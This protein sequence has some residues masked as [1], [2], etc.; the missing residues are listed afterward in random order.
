LGG[1]KKGCYH[2]DRIR[3]DPEQ[4]S[5]LS[6]TSALLKHK[7]AEMAIRIW[8]WRAPCTG[9][10]MVD[11]KE[12][13]LAAPA[14]PFNEAVWVLR[15]NMPSNAHPEGIWQRNARLCGR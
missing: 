7:L 2:L 1:A 9:H 13:G 3:E 12:V 6:P 8:T 14:N 15:K 4:F 11:D 5:P 10:Q